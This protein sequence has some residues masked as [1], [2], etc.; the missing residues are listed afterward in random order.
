MKKI[1]CNK[2]FI[3]TL[4][5]V[6]CIILTSLLLLLIKPNYEKYFKNSISEYRENFFVYKDKDVSVKV[7]SGQR[8]KTYSLNGVKDKLVDYGV[9]CVSILDSTKLDDD[10]RFVLTVDDK[11]YTGNLEKNPYDGS[12]MADTQN[13][14]NDNAKVSLIVAS[15]NNSYSVVLNNVANTF[16]IDLNKAIDIA[17][18]AMISDVKENMVKGYFNGEVCITIIT[19]ATNIF[20]SY[21]WYSRIVTANGSIYSCAIDVNTGKVLA[22]N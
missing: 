8:E 14:I 16:K 9:I 5:I 12:L 17:S 15:N 2:K 7:Y 19:D 20:S 10:Y 18:K 1:N 6:L 13:R 3:I 21:Y 11:K 22:K 4:I